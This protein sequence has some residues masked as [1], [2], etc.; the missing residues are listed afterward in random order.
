MK[1]LSKKLVTLLLAL[2][3]LLSLGVPAFANAPIE[4]EPL[5]GPCAHTW[6][7]QTSDIR[8]RSLDDEYCQP[9]QQVYQICS[10]CNAVNPDYDIHDEWLA[11]KQK[12]KK[13]SLIYATCNGTTQSWYY[14]CVRCGYAIYEKYDCPKAGHTGPCNWLPI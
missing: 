2:M 13:S 1:K 6:V 4:V 9:Y 5:N 12:H 11:Y 14:Q 7:K 10:K 3:V 8:Y